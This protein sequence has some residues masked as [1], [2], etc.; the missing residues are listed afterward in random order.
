MADDKADIQR[1]RWL[2]EMREKRT[3]SLYGD[4]EHSWGREA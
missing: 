1:E 4:L 2:A 3:F